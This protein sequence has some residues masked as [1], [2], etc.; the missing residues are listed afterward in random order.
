MCYLLSPLAKLS[1]AA[2][3]LC[4]LPQRPVN[5][6]VPSLQ[7]AA[8]VVHNSSKLQWPQIMWGSCFLDAP[9]VSYPTYPL[10][11]STDSFWILS[12][13]D[14]ASLWCLDILLLH[15]HGIR[16]GDKMVCLS[17]VWNDG[18]AVFF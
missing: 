6:N 7:Q 11:H 10:T 16:K 8:N 9:P 4:L 1:L 5:T 15:Q 2:C 12:R 13:L 14:A 17:Q 18:L 3:I